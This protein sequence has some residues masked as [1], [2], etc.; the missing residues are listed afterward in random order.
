MDPRM[1]FE[2]TINAFSKS[3]SLKPIMKTKGQSSAFAR[4]RSE[5]EQGKTDKRGAVPPE[6]DSKISAEQARMD[7]DSSS[8]SASLYT[9][10]RSKESSPPQTGTTGTK[11]P[12]TEE[13]QFEREVRRRL[14]LK[15]KPP[16]T[17]GKRNTKKVKRRKKITKKQRL[18]KRNTKKIKKRKRKTRIKKR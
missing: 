9:P 10:E 1:F 12:K 6:T 17:G 13:E 5:I 2:E 18:K 15:D 7:V 16:P 14:Q 4:D 11:R 3:G 8:G